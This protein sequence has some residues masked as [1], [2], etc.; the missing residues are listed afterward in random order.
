MGVI[1][2]QLFAIALLNCIK[3]LQNFAMQLQLF[4]IAL[5]D[6]SNFLEFL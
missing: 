6:R 1:T 5:L 4:A 2:L 3:A